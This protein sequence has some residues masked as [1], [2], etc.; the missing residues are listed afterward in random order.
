M[1]DDRLRVRQAGS[2]GV[3]S[4]KL[5]DMDATHLYLRDG[6]ETLRVPRAN[7]VSVDR[8]QGYDWKASALQG[9]AI[10]AML[11]FLNVST[12]RCNPSRDDTFIVPL[13][14]ALVGLLAAPALAPRR[15]RSVSSW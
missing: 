8:A 5:V 4:G 3:V 6:P 9:A 11:G 10:G 2:G 1:V 13:S 14:S 12:C 7:V 15:W